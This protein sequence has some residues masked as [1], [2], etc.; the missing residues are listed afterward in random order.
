MSTT[1]PP[2]IR[3]TATAKAAGC[4]AKLSP[5]VLDAALKKLPVQHDPNR[6]VGFETADDAAIYRLSP[7]IAIVQTVDF[8]TP[9]VDDPFEFG[10]VAATNALSDVYAMGGRPVSSLTILAFPANG[11]PAVLEKIL[12][13]GLSKM[14]EANCTIVGG[15]S[16]RDD[17]IKF[18]YAVTGVVHPEKFW[19]NVGAEAGDVLILTKAI[20]TGV[21]ATALKQEKARPAWVAAATASMTTLNRAA[22]DALHEIEDAATSAAAPTPIHAVTDVTGF[23]LLGHAR[24]VAI[25]SRVSLELDHTKIAYLAGAIDAS[26]AKFFSGGMANNREFVESCTDFASSVPE[27]FRALFF[28]PQ[29]AGGL[30]I[31]IDPTQAD[32]TLGAMHRRGVD[33]RI[34]GG[35]SEKSAHF[36]NVV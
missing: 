12:S 31:A 27:E 32:A 19:K 16:I 30:L 6:L 13:G 15:H 23:G 20:G 28:D 24:E 25:G 5:G 1:T 22:A 36:I 18:G 9:I 4:A 2:P 17:E 21:I 33:A 8:F 3:L 10:Q 7:E 11:D 29:T 35:A 14:C 34:V 26:R